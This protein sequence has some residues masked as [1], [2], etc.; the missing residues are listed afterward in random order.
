MRIFP[1]L[2]DSRPAYL[3][4]IPATSVLLMPLGARTLLDHL[5]ARF[6]QAT[7]NPVTI[8]PRFEVDAAY[9][10]AL[11][12]ACP[13]VGTVVG[14]RGL[15][16][17]VHAYEP[18]DWLLIADPCNYPSDGWE[19]AGLVADLTENPRIVRHLVTSD[20]SSAGTKEYVQYNEEGRVERIQRFY[21]GVTW[22]FSS[23]ISCT[24]LPVSC[25]LLLK[26]FPYASLSELR[27]AMA[28]LGVP[29]RD[30]PLPCN[31]FDLNDERDLLSLSE[32]FVIEA[33]PTTARGGS[34]GRGQAAWA[35]PES[36]VHPSARLLG[37]VI[38]Q[39]GVIVEENATVIGPALLGADCR[40]GRRA[41]VAQCLV[42]P[43]TVVPEDAT[44]LHRVVSDRLV[45]RGRYGA[46]AVER[47][48]AGPI[49]WQRASAVEL[50]DERPSDR[51]YA[52]LK[53]VPEAIL[54]CAALLLLLP[55]LL[56]LA[57]LIR[58]GSRGPI[59]YGDTREGRTGRP[60]R[61][62][63]LRT[64]IPGRRR[65]DSGELHQR[66]QMDG[67]Q[68]KLHR[69]P[70][71]TRVGRW[72]VHEPGRAAPARQHLLGQ[73]SLVGPRP[74]PFRENQVCVPWR[75][76]RLSV[77][78]GIT[79]LWQ[80]CRRD[81]ASGDFHQ[82]IYFDLLYVQHMSLWLDLKIVVATLITLGGRW[83]MPL[84]WILAN[85]GRREAQA[86]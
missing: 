22:P 18:S 35:A 1:V 12:S 82:W 32:R 24:L 49:A 63:K 61:C 30:I 78:P 2:L 33:A 9:E 51:L 55:V 68:F 59:L 19:L 84:A 76:G 48:A 81:R 75:R 60:F 27:R 15:A 38:I 71:V 77:R 34:G 43:G 23:G 44:V 52:R 50:R 86:A 3:G 36:T 46:A 10:A 53:C 54:A 64:M 65:A 14:A 74:S 16:Q 45:W 83:S 37:P 70:R 72:L 31:A 62:W 29:G 66:N 20:T 57:A 6:S 13:T 7:L 26:G 79:G 25:T 85:R 17:Q 11:R 69:D 67:P 8:L 73:M 21:D 58:L 56:V 28:S 47:R 42:S 80:V 41:T 5:C 4:R 40:V 39:A